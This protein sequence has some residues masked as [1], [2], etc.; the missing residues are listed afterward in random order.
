VSITVRQAVAGDEGVLRDARIEALTDAPEAFGSTLEREL[1]RTP[2]DWR[3]WMSPGTV[4]LLDEDGRA[5][6]LVAG[7]ARDDD[8]RSIQLMAMWVHPS[9]RGT[10][11]AGAL[12]AALVGWAAQQ[13]AREVHLRVVKANERARRFYERE[14]FRQFGDDIIRPRDG[15][16]EIEM[17]RPMGD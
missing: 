7:A 16:V 10:G 8:P 1:A 12:V 17:R 4:F 13:G 2:E 3:R 14:G 9:Q 5:R 6:G 15:A 11:A